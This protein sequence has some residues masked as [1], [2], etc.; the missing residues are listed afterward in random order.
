MNM[1]E[2]RFADTHKWQEQFYR[3]H[4][5]TVYN[6]LNNGLKLQSGPAHRALPDVLVMIEVYHKFRQT[7][8]TI[9]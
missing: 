7:A 1:P 5:V 4:L 2:Y 8:L 9:S 6:I 3:T